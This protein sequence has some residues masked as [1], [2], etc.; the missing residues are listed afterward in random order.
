MFLFD[1]T[2]IFFFFPP[3]TDVVCY[4][5]NVEYDVQVTFFCFY[6]DSLCAVMF[7]APKINKGRASSC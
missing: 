4:V 6:L 5:G 3:L 2:D 7:C 1:F